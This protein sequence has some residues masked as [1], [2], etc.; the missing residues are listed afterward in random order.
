MTRSRPDH[1]WA[2]LRDR[3]RTELWP[4]PTTAC[5]VAVLMGVTLPQLEVG[6]GELAPAGLQH[7]LFGGGPDAARTVLSAVAGSMITVTALTFSLT[8]VTLQLASSQFSPRLL[9]TFT[10]DLV[11]QGTLAL[12]LGTFTYSLTALRTVRTA[13]SS[14]AEFVPD[15]SVSLAYVLAVASVVG[16]VFFLA[17][18]V[19]TIRVESMLRAV[20]QDAQATANRELDEA[21]TVPVSLESMRPQGPSRALIASTSGFLVGVREDDLKEAALRAGIQVVIDV[22]PGDSIVAGTPVGA[23]WTLDPGEGPIGEDILDSLASSLVAGFERTSVQDVSLGLRQLTDV[24][25]KALSPG[26]NDPTTAIHALSHS[27]ALL[28]GLVQRDLGPRVLRDDEGRV[29]V[30]LARPDLASLL[31]LALDQPARYG[32]S[33]PEVLAR[34][35]TLLRE[36]AWV[37]APHQH[38]EVKDALSRLMTLVDRADMIPEDRTRLVVGASRV[39]QAIDGR[40]EGRGER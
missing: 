19:Q 11:V 7:Y 34:L 20:H 36:V 14:R 40:W 10:R 16:L 33:D 4:L 39:D 18:L 37:G 35:L 15:V 2:T 17:H 8:V 13:S 28:C 9:R 32:M 23:V 3:F 24:A 38:P 27:S 6:S 5:A 12:F 29:L 1:V 21:Q 31:H 25:V 26:I 30:V 22:L